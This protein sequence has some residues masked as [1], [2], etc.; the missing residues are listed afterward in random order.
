MEGLLPVGRLLYFPQVLNRTLA[1]AILL[2]WGVMTV[3]L[4][5]TEFFSAEGQSLPVP[6]DFVMKLMFH[7]EQMIDL[8]LTSQG[9]RLDGTLH[10]QPKRLLVGMDGR[11]TPV[12]L[13]TGTSSFALNLPETGVQRVVLRGLVELTDQQRCQR[14]EV[15]TS[16]HEARQVGPGLTLFLEGSPERDDWH[17]ILRQAGET[18][19]ED[20]GSMAKIIAAADPH[21][22]GLNFAGIQQIQRQQL[23][24]AHVTAHRGTLRLSGEPVDTYVIS[25]EEGGMVAA[26]V[27]FNQLGQILAIKTFTGYDLYDEGVT[28]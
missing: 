10:L 6:V 16:L 24:S 23:A 3:Q 17:Y 9:R 19:R 11:E 26:T 18:V 7:H 20:T 1:A 21:I 8:I 22:P 27:H 12:N 2:F 15:T 28:P 5:R 14:L 25:I 13:L 4:I